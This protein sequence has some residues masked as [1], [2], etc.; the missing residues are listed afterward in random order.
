MTTI[1]KV[2]KWGNSLAVRLPKGAV[3]RLKLHAGHSISI[4]ERSDSEIRLIT[5]YPEP[6]GIKDLIAGITPANRH[7]E[8]SWGA[9]RGKELW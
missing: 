4:V 8:T 2:Q 9:A 1:T 6:A 3:R 5:A 7:S